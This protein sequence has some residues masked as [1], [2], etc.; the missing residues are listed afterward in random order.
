MMCSRA[1]RLWVAAAFCAGIALA[2]TGGV[3]HV[4]VILGKQPGASAVT[5]APSPTGSITGSLENRV[6]QGTRFTILDP[7]GNAVTAAPVNAADGTFVLPPPRIPLQANFTSCLEV[8]GATRIC[9]DPGAMAAVVNMR[10]TA[11]ALTAAPGG[12]VGG[13]GPRTPCPPGSTWNGTQCVG[14]QP[15]PAMMIPPADAA[16]L[17]NVQI[18]R[19]PGGSWR[20]TGQTGACSPT[21][22]QTLAR[23][24]AVIKSKSNDKQLLVVSP[25]GNIGCK[26]STNGT[27]CTAAEVN[28]FASSLKIRHDA[29]MSAIRNM[30]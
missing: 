18:N 13:P 10:Q 19:T 20:C 21:E 2:Q 15:N 30:K 24:T 6:P 9:S 28:E 17:S 12:G 29:A 7:Q 23:T 14:M 11:G 3:K 27:P 5:L 1:T 25:D 22:V 4:Q 8:P 16:V 26:D